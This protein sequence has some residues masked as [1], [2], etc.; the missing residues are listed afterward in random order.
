M[1]TLIR[2]LHSVSCSS[3]LFVVFLIVLSTSCRTQLTP[4]ARYGDL[5]QLDT[6]ISFHSESI[7]QMIAPYRTELERIM[8]DTVGYLKRAMSKKRPEGL[9][10]NLTARM[11]FDRA[12]KLDSSLDMVIMNHG[13]LRTPLPKGAITRSKVF[14]LM[15]FDNELV[16]V[17]LP[18]SLLPELARTIAVKG[19][20][21]IW[22]RNDGY[23]VINDS[24]G[25]FHLPRSDDAEF[26]RIA[27][28]DYLANGGDHYTVFQKGT[29]FGGKIHLQ[30]IVIRDIFL[31]AFQEGSSQGDSTDASINNIIRLQ[32]E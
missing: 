9:L 22:I 1:S 31:E 8:R 24:T 25:T 15:P 7:D 32:D 4:V 14:E 23:I 27:T 28:S 21:P 5:Q 20:D 2:Y 6:S 17:E 26:I 30:G 19:G 16:I 29:E 12:L 10:G 11:V 3:F 13:G 18:V